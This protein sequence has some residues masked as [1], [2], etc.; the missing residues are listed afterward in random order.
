MNCLKAYKAKEIKTKCSVKIIIIK[1]LPLITVGDLAFHVCLTPHL[2]CAIMN[3]PRVTSARP[4]DPKKQI[5]LQ[6]DREA[7]T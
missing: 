4:K 1:S 3:Y 5:Q 6:Q 2:V 7:A